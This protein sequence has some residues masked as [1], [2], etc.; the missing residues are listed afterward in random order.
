MTVGQRVPDSCGT[1]EVGVFVKEEKKIKE[2]PEADRVV[3]MH[4]VVRILVVRGTQLLQAAR[5][6][7]PVGGLMLELYPVVS[8]S[9]EGGAVNGYNAAHETIKRSLIPPPP[10]CSTF[11]TPPLFGPQL[12][13][14]G[15]VNSKDAFLSVIPV[16]FVMPKSWKVR[17]SF[18]SATC[19]Y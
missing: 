6:V 8:F 15:W 11:A 12:D 14:G 5:P 17:C 3:K 19:S 4:R 2:A 1:A 7:H 10:L 9:R 16:K 13:I 18:T